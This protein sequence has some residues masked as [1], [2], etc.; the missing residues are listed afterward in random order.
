MR[1]IADEL[2]KDMQRKEEA[3]VHADVGR[4]PPKSLETQQ[5]S[6]RAPVNMTN[7]TAEETLDTSFLQDEPPVP[8]LHAP[9]DTRR[10]TEVHH[11]TYN[12]AD[13]SFHKSCFASCWA[14]AM[15]LAMCQ[16]STHHIGHRELT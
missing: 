11:L 14:Q 8:A 16:P 4:S 9:P 5:V 6:I 15:S 1:A 10:L 13:L 7:V 12:C 3:A 2:F